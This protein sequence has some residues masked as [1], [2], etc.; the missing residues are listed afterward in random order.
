MECKKCGSSYFI[1]IHDDAGC[2]YMVCLMCNEIIE[3]KETDTFQD[4]GPEAP[5]D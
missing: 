1:V 2:Y 4:V 3:D 5:N